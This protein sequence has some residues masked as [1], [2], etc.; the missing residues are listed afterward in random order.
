MKPKIV[1]LA[2]LCLISAAVYARY[3]DADKKN[4][5][6]QKIMDANGKA[7]QRGSS[8]LGA[9]KGATGPGGSN[10]NGNNNG[11]GSGGGT[12]GGN[13]S[14]IDTS[15]DD[16]E[17]PSGVTFNT[18]SDSFADTNGCD[19]ALDNFIKSHASVISVPDANF[20]S[21]PCNFNKDCAADLWYDSGSV[22]KHNAE[23]I[24]NNPTLAPGK[25]SITIASPGT[26]TKGNASINIPASLMF[27]VPLPGP[28]VTY[29]SN[30]SDAQ[31]KMGKPVLGWSRALSNAWRAISKFRQEYNDDFKAKALHTHICVL[32]EDTLLAGSGY[33][34]S[35]VLTTHSYGRVYI[36]RCCPN[37]RCKKGEKY[38]YLH[39]QCPS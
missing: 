14:G 10:P 15:G 33:S 28:A 19:A 38:D 36:L 17:A 3:L 34:H 16:P 9:N 6:Q 18:G 31:K 5:A 29:L 4:E 22:E 32:G 37:A 11:G 12:G 27:G 23:S 8:P 25:L 24:L 26:V 13:Q 20:A 7:G 35:T 1:L 2:L 39:K 21:S 30:M